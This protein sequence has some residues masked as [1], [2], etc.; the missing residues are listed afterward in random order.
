MGRCS[1]STQLLRPQNTWLMASMLDLLYYSASASGSHQ[2]TDL[3]GKAQGLKRENNLLLSQL[4][5]AS[6]C[7][8]A[9]ISENTL[10]KQEVASLQGT[11]L[12]VGAHAAS[13]MP[14]LHVPCDAGAMGPHARHENRPHSCER[15]PCMHGPAWR[16][17]MQ[18]VPAC[19]RPSRRRM[20]ERRFE[21]RLA[22]VG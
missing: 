3:L 12:Q 4:A 14:A 20:Q 18:D 15:K 13:T 7:L 2:L 8:N 9:V 16:L 10:L 11:A 21:G 17:D 19:P 22:C 1:S 6:K 5:R